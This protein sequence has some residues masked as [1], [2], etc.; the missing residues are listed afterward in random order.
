MLFQKS[1]VVIEFLGFIIWVIARVERDVELLK[2]N[3]FIKDNQPPDRVSHW[4]ANLKTLGFDDEVFKG[5]LIS[6][7]HLAF[8]GFVEVGILKNRVSIISKMWSNGKD[9]FRERSG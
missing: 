6:V 7:G 4:F 8:L 1:E 5:L 2:V 9:G 3:V